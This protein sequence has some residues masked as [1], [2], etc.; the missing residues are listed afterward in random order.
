MCSLAARGL[1]VEMIAIMHEAEP[2]GHLLIAGKALDDAALALQVGAPKR[3]V[4]R[5]RAE[6][7]EHGVIERL[8]SGVLTNPRM[9]R[10]EATRLKRAAGGKDS[11]RNPKV[12][13][14][15]DTIKDILEGGPKLES[16]GPPQIP[17][18]RSQSTDVK[19]SVATQLAAPPEKERPTPTEWLAHFMP[20]LRKHDFNVDNTAG[21]I[22]KAL[23]RKGRT[24][25]DTEAAIIGL[26]YMRQ[27]GRVKAHGTS[28]K[29][30]LRLLYAE[31]EDA[32]RPIWNEA[33]EEYYRQQPRKTPKEWGKGKLRIDVA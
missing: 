11:L 6:L 14:P 30:D 2:Y 4:E 33:E 17:D 10:D 21:S 29:L 15:K 13:R 31:K 18:A 25:D 8:E 20:L 27:A 19:T 22:L 1:L 12:P 16:E 28:D 26:Y 5:L 3:D 7:E 32:V 23:L 24:Q 9:I